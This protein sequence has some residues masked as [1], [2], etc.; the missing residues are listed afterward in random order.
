MARG[1]R[2]STTALVAGTGMLAAVGLAG[3][4]QAGDDARYHAERYV[5]VVGSTAARAV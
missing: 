4:A 5:K 1:N 3:P 2:V